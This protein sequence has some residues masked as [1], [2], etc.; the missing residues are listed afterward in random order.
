MITRRA[1]VPRPV[2]AP[3]TVGIRERLAEHQARFDARFAAYFDTL[4]QRPLPRGDFVPE[5]L[6][7][8]RDMPSRRDGLPPAEASSTLVDRHR[9]CGQLRSRHWLAP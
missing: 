9:T 8:L 2:I 1:L 5:C 6:G 4:A 3:T 7:L